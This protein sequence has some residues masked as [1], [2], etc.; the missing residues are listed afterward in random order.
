MIAQIFTEFTQAPVANKTLAIFMLC[1]MIL[2]VSYGTKA[3]YAKRQFAKRFFK[4]TMFHS[5]YFKYTQALTLSQHV[6]RWC[7]ERPARSANIAR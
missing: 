3:L 4:R 5:R 7:D 6:I 1:T 2:A